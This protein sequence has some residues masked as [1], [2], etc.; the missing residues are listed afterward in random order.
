MTRRTFEKIMADPKKNEKNKT[1]KRDSA[2]IRK[3]QQFVR[4]SKDAGRGARP[5]LFP[6]DLKVVQLGFSRLAWRPG[7]TALL[8]HT[9]IELNMDGEKPSSKPSSATARAEGKEEA[10]EDELG[11]VKEFSPDA[12]W[13]VDERNGQV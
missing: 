12:E 3:L 8:R 4:T 5:E 2:G 11:T 1:I 10:M 9:Y 6:R 13:M 7:K